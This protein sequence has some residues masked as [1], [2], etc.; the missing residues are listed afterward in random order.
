M[1]SGTQ[2]YRYETDKGNIFHA[3]TDDS[4]SLASCRGT[5]PTEAPTENI[6]FEN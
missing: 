3:R 2:R 4:A 5:E 1:A 6:T